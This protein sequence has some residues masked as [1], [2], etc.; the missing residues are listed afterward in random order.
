MH[1]EEIK[2]AIRMKGT[3]PTALADELKVSRSM[4]SHVINGK[5]KSARIATR[6]VQVI[7]L[8]ADK[9]WPTKAAAPKLRRDR[10]GASA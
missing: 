6:I 9:I 2:A 8:P 7:G 10:A 5:A 4:V 3:T 1:P